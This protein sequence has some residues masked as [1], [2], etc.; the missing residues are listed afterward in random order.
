MSDKEKTA[1]IFTN[2]S[3]FY[4]LKKLVIYR[5]MSSNL[6]INYALPT[7][8]LFYKVLGRRLTN[9]VVNKT[10][11]QVFT[12][13]ETINSLL[14]DIQSIEQRGVGGIANYVVEGIEEM[15]EQLISK[16]YNDLM[17]S[18]TALTEDKPEGHLAIKLTA[19]I[20]IGIMTRVSNA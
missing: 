3:T 17:D 2:D 8:N 13:G 14:V 16:V 18:I 5:T 1:L 9:F 7:M 15:N 19:M 11:G 20:A 10:A 4:L 6:F 12:S